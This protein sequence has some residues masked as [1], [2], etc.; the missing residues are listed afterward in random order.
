ME[1]KLIAKFNPEIK[2]KFNSNHRK[3]GKCY[4]N[5]YCGIAINKTYKNLYP[6]VTI[7]TYQVS[8]YGKI[9]ACIWINGNKIYSSGS[10]SASGYGY[11]LKSTAVG[12]AIRNSGF[13]L[14]ENIAGR[15]S[16]LIRA[17]ILAIGE[18]IGSPIEYLHNS[19]A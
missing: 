10:G 11:D 17:A 1:A 18:A 8:D 5:E 3:E 2:P 19:N 6:A 12:E 4:F 13:E 15:G 16:I 9:Y 14:S 7:R